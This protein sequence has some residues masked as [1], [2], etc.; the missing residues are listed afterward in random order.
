M[1]PMQLFKSEKDQFSK[2][3]IFKHGKKAIKLQIYLFSRYFSLIIT[4]D[5]NQLTEVQ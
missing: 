2:K 5:S 4:G 3:N 1:R